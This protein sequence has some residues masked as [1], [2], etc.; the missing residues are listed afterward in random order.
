MYILFMTTTVSDLMRKNVYTIE[1]SASIQDTAK[2]MN[3]KKVSSLLVLDRND[4]PI[5]LVTERDLARKVCIN[6][7]R[8]SEVK[9]KEIMSAPLIT[10]DSKSS[11]S[12]AT[13][14]ML[15]YNVRHLLVIDDKS[16]DANKPIGMIT[17]LEFTRYE[18]YPRNDEG[19]DNL[20]K[21]LEYYI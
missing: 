9:N 7:L 21:I 15:R 6:D 20:E 5:G 16:E 18:E 17:P 14:L 8:T 1:E 2:K 12:T 10:I 3:D 19:K 4:K 11:P 13:D